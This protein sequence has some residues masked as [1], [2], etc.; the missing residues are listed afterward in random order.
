MEGKTNGGQVMRTRWSIEDLLYAEGRWGYSRQEYR[1]IARAFFSRVKLCIEYGGA[2]VVRHSGE[3]GDQL[4]LS[5]LI[6]YE[7]GSKMVKEDK[8]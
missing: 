1:N 3:S 4:E 8:G 7:S 2:F 6:P 5:K